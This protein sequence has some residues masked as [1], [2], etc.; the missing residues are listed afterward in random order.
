MKAY[1][2]GDGA[3][4]YVNYASFKN[5]LKYGAMY[6]EEVVNGLF[7]LLIPTNLNE[8]DVKQRY[9]HFLVDEETKIF[10]CIFTKQR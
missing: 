1:C 9:R 5:E 8:V 3:C 7:M 4:S 2:L 10:E 6:Q